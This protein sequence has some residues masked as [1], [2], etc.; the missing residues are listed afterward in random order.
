L[1][2]LVVRTKKSKG[3]YVR[4]WRFGFGDRGNFP[5]ALTIRKDDFQLEYAVLPWR[6]LLAWNGAFPFLEV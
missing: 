5:W 6:L 3:E 2:I 4:H 1:G